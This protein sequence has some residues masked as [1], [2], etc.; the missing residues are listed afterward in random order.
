[1]LELP[2]F[3]LHMTLFP[4][5]RLPLQIFEPRYLDMIKNCMKQDQGF[6]IVSI[7]EGQEVGERPEVYSVGTS[8]NIVDWNKLPNGLLG[9]TAEGSE[10]VRIHRIREQDDKLLMADVDYIQ[11]EKS[12]HVPGEFS[13]LVDILKSLKQNPMIQ[14]LNLNIDYEDASAVSCRLSELLP[15]MVEDKQALLEL[16]EPLERLQRLQ[17]LLDVLGDEFNIPPA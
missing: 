13:R 11:Q 12:A 2:L 14:N 7:R 8:A 15:F 5:G 6:V 9:I 10:R 16:N 3:P 4:G 1:M 17:S